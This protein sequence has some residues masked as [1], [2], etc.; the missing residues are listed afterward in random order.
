MSSFGRSDWRRFAFAFVREREQLVLTIG[1]DRREHIDETAQIL[2][3]HARVRARLRSRLALRARLVVDLAQQFLR[4]VELP[5]GGVVCHESTLS[6]RP[7]PQ[8]SAG[9]ATPMLHTGPV[10]RKGE[11]AIDPKVGHEKPRARP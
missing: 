11:I 6:L 9:N 2:V 8:T 5:L 3:R 7:A 4:K 10:D 1:C